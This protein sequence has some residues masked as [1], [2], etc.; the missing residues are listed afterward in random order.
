GIGNLP[1][2]ISGI[3]L[4]VLAFVAFTIGWIGALINLARLRE[5]TWFV[6]TILFSVVCLIVYLFAGPEASPTL[7]NPQMYE[8]PP[9]H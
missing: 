8:M 4:Y 9:E 2:F 3:V 6:L 1:L 5:W 7:K